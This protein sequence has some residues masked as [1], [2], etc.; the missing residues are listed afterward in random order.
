MYILFPL[1]S[2]SLNQSISLIIDI[3]LSLFHILFSLSVPRR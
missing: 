1:S 2:L 3:F